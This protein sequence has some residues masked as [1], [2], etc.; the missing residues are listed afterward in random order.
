VKAFD[1]PPGF[2][3]EVKNIAIDFDGVIHN[4]DKGFFDGTCYGDPIPGSI[5]A[6]AKIA[7]SFEIIIFTAKA[8]P[9]RPLVK[10]KTGTELVVEWLEKYGIMKYVKEVTSEKPRALLYIDD[11]G[12]RFENWQSTLEFMEKM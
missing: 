4:S 6:V 10:G 12:Y 2:D 11:N 7:Q 3:S 5:E 1:F 9:N 8:K